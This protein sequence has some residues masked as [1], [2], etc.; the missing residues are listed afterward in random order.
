MALK[1][2]LMAAENSCFALTG[3]YIYIY[4]YIYIFYIYIQ[5]ENSYFTL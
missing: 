4:I 2:E 5:I 3:I 1:I